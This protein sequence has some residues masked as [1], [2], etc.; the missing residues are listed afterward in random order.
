VRVF[1]NKTFARFAAKEDIDDA[2]LKAAVNEMERG[3]L[4]ADLGGGIYKKRIARSGSGKS[5]GYRVIVC[6]RRG[7]RTF[8]VY[9]F[10][11]SD[12]ENIDDCELR[13]Y[14]RLA[15]YMFDMTETQIEAELK[16]G[17]LSEVMGDEKNAAKI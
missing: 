17:K 16:I 1:K 8:F 7:E 12:R 15:K 3:L 4:D 9:G 5:S 2:A 10:A 6:F 14:K 11:K 13:Q